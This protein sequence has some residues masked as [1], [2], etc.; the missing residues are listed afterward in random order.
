MVFSIQ[1]PTPGSLLPHFLISLAVQPSR[2]PLCVW[3]HKPKYTFS[4]VTVSLCPRPG[5][6]WQSMRPTIVFWGALGGRKHSGVCLIHLFSLS[7]LTPVTPEGYR[8]MP[9]GFFFPLNWSLQ[10]CLHM[11]EK[12]SHGSL[13]SS[14][15]I[16]PQNSKKLTKIVWLIGWYWVQKWG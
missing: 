2:V 14:V 16:G 3:K 1:L 10:S 7:E 13:I 4:D 12:Q 8:K 15:P 6:S 9:L 11:S 5:Q